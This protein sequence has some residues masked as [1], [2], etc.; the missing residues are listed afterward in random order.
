MKR[1]AT[2][3]FSLTF[4]KVQEQFGKYA[5]ELEQTGTEA[6]EYVAEAT[7]DA[8]IDK[9]IGTR[10]VAKTAKGDYVGVLKDY[11]SQF[12][13]LL[14]VN[15][16][17]EWQITVKQGEKSKHERGLTLEKSGNDLV[18]R[19][20][21]P[22]RLT[23]KHIYWKE[24]KPDA[25][26]EKINKVIEPFG[27]LRLNLMPPALNLKVSPFEQIKTPIRFH[28]QNYKKILC[29]FESVRVADIV[30]LKNYGIVRHRTE[31]YEA[32]LLDFGALADALLTSK[33]QELVLEGN[34]STTA[35]NIYNGYLTNLPRER[36]DFAEVDQQVNQRWTVSNFFTTLDRKL[37]PVSKHYFLGLLPLRKPRRVLA[38]FSLIQIIHS[39]EKRKRDPLLPLA[40]LTICNAN[41]RRRRGTYKNRVLIK[42]RKR[43]LGF[44]TRPSHV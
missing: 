15:Y 4:G 30:L 33:D 7:Y 19:S 11:T 44:L 16:K 24:G 25:K 40:Y 22:F 1:V 35:L 39:D 31:K 26:R 5:K 13:Q 34:P 2:E 23:L 36:M 27:E 37:R 8:L 28:Y 29:N 3:A 12:I 18:I 32:K 38:L 14:N 6:V 20:K 21:S 41:S 42:K 43:L 17:N 9:L 10:V